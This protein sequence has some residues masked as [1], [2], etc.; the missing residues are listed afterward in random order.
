MRRCHRLVAIDQRCSARLAIPQEARFLRLLALL[1]AHSGDSPLW[2]A[3]SAGAILWGN[4]DWHALGWRILAGTLAAGTAVTLLKQLFRRRRPPGE[5]RGF[6]SR[7]DRHAFPSGHAG[8]SACLAVLTASLL[9]PWAATLFAIWAALVGIARV[10][11]GVH[12][13]S[14]ILGGWGIGLLIGLSLLRVF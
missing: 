7:L 12:F 8:R 14:D 1:A 9:S 2:L 10:A 13:A 11:L 3:I 5:G 4:D 6:Y